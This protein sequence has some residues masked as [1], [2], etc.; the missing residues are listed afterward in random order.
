MFSLGNRDSLLSSDLMAPL[1]VPH[2]AQQS[3]ERVSYSVTWL[4]RSECSVLLRF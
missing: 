4:L 3:D 2:V 1:I